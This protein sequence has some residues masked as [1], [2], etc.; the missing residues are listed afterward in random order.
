MHVA[1]PLV[2]GILIYLLWRSPSLVVFHWLAGI[3]FL[4]PVLALRSFAQPI[5]PAMPHWVLFSLPDGLW[6]YSLSSAILLAWQGHSSRSW[7]IWFVLAAILGLFSEIG[8]YMDLVPGTFDFADALCYVIG[9]A[10]PLLFF[11]KGQRHEKIPARSFSR[12]LAI[13]C[14]PGLRQRGL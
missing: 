8:Q 12:H 1:M 14:L 13:L 5:G 3:G 2:A 4:E 9:S 7:L 6:A 11:T 10:V